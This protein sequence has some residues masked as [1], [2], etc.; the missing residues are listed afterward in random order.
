MGCFSWDTLPRTPEKKLNL[1]HGLDLNKVIMYCV[2]HLNDYSYIQ[3]CLSD[4]YEQSD[5]TLHLRNE[6]TH[7][8]L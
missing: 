8:G 4:V 5:V 2:Q 6:E 7:K 3:R 1:Q